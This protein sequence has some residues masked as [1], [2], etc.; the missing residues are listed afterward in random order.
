M[1]QERAACPRPRRADEDG[2][3]VVSSL[4]GVL[5]FL[6]FVLLVVQVTL[7]MFTASVVQTA[8]LDGAT[9]GAGAVQ[10]ASVAAGRDRAEAVLGA[11]ADDATVSGRILSD[12]SGE[13]LRVTVRVAPPSG[14]VR[15]LGVSAIE[16]SAEAR[17]EQ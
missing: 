3:G 1:T 7:F 11:L 15:G 16:R 17:I 8:A 12:P 4:L 6:T 14:L 5:V 2:V 10:T 9:H 13:R